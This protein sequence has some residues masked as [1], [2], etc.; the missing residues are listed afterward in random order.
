M[1]DNVSQLF[2]Y[3]CVLTADY[4][5]SLCYT[6]NK[7]PSRLFLLLILNPHQASTYFWYSVGAPCLMSQSTSSI[8]C[9]Y[10]CLTRCHAL[11]LFRE[12]RHSGQFIHHV[13]IYVIHTNHN[14]NASMRPISYSSCALFIYLSSFFRWMDN[15]IWDL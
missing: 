1:K 6:G 5:A 10:C 4:I 9:F 3:Y 2:N 8:A 15:G 7:Q 11:R 14:N 12:I 13:Q